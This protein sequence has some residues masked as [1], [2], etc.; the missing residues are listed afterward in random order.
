[1]IRPNEIWVMV[2]PVYMRGGIDGL[3]LRVQNLL[4]RNPCV[5]DRHI[6]VS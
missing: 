1:M 2:E 3:S 5:S 4:G 6:G